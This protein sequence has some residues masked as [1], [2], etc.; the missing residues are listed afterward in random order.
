[1]RPNCILTYPRDL[2]AICNLV[3]TFPNLTAIIWS[4][5]LS[6]ELL[7]RVFPM[8][9]PDYMF[10]EM[11]AL[12]DFAY[13]TGSPLVAGSPQ[14]GQSHTQSVSRVPTC[15]MYNHPAPLVL[16]GKIFS[17]HVCRICMNFYWTLRNSWFVFKSS[18]FT[19][20]WNKFLQKLKQKRDN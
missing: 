4:K 10:H 14:G 3:A 11:R 19:E 9:F 16:F 18:I 17:S 20:V 1:M 2:C 8:P 5:F 12:P 7:N 6:F 15:I 13:L